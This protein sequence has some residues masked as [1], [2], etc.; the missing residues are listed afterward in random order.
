ME[1]LYLIIKLSWVWGFPYTY[2]SL[3]YIYK[4]YLGEYLHFWYLK[5]FGD[6]H[7]YIL[8]NIF[9]FNE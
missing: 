6:I 1:V 4:A 8:K 9:I 5:W 7:I 2:I 3:I